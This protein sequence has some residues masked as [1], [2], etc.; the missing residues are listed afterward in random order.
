[1]LSL[2]IGLL[3]LC[4]VI[5]FAVWIIR[6]LPIPQPFANILIAIVA[7]ILVLSY[8]GG[9]YGWMHSRWRF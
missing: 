7:L 3:V 8:F 5:C 2:L 4:L 1:M 9:G 6:L